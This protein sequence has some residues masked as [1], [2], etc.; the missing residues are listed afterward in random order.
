MLGK[1][2]HRG[3]WGVVPDGAKRNYGSRRFEP[4]PTPHAF[5]YLALCALVVT[6]CS[7]DGRTPLVIYSPHGRDLLTLLER[8][9]EQLHPGVDVRWLDMGSQEVYDRVRSERANP[10]ADVWFGGPATI[11]ARAAADSLLEPYRPSW[12][13]AIDP[14]GRG[15][16]DLYFAAYETPAAVVYAVRSPW[17]AVR[18]T[19]TR[20]GR[21]SNTWG[22]SRPSCSRRARP[23]AC[24]R[25]LTCPPTRCPPGRGTYGAR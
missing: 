5:W 17:C 12:A 9:F 2:Q 21:S 6:G 23:T 24:P 15:R 11:F 20:P 13:G 22:Q 25:G 1:R 10:Q 14:H 7:S 8:R 3:D 16:G 18:D 19:A 4:L